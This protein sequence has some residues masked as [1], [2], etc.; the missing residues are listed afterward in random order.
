MT[1]V[2]QRSR[3]AGVVMVSQRVMGVPTAK[4]QVNVDAQLARSRVAAIDQVTVQGISNL[5]TV[6]II[7]GVGIRGV[8]T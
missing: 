8:D 7:V 6:G 3:H 1:K 5:H 2:A 4:V